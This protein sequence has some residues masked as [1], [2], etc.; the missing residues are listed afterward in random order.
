M[1]AKQLDLIGMRYSMLMVVE[2]LPSKVYGDKSKYHKKRMSVLRHEFFVPNDKLVL[3]SFR[4][5]CKTI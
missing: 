2:K 4:K 5:K 1:G 3:A